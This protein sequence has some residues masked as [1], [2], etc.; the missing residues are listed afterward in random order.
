MANINLPKIGFGTWQLSISQ[1]KPAILTAIKSG[2]RLIDTA[3]IYQ[4]EEGVGDALKESPVPRDELIIATKIWITNLDFENVLKSTENS[5]RKLQ[6]S[7][8]DLLYVHWPALKYN[9]QKTFKAF[10]QL[11]DQGK[12]RA[13]CVSNFTP[14][15]LDEA[16]SFCDKP[17]FANQVEHHPW[18]HQKEL[19]EYCK[20]KKIAFIAYSPLGRANIFETSELVQIARNHQTTPAQV[21]LAWEI[22]HGAIP[23]PKATREEHI[24]NNFEAIHLQLTPDEIQ[25]IDKI[26][27]QKRFINPFGI[28]PK[29]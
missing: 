6:L 27:T 28:H 3:Q 11:V 5:L 15:L 12:I 13:I 8:V 10:S 29:W 20:Q 1:C 14:K 16:I 24:K 25:M 26:K 18:L 7:M 23:I 17:I 19:L 2:Y 9:P 4:N 21:A 22:Q